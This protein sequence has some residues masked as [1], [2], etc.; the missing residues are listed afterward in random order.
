MI[1]KT[2]TLLQIKIILSIFLAINMTSAQ[3]ESVD[4]SLSSPYGPIKSEFLEMCAPYIKSDL[5][6]NNAC[7]LYFIGLRNGYLAGDKKATDRAALYYALDGDVAPA[8]DLKVKYWLKAKNAFENKAFQT[9][10]SHKVNCIRAL[11]V[12]SFLRDF[13]SFLE[14]HRR[15][16][17][18][19][20]LFDEFVQTQYAGKC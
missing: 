12:E 13:Y 6:S 9:L 5:V 3:A 2:P 4:K 11:P 14:K 19:T 10:D 17:G 8:G 15:D 1:I 7:F 16:N 18:V 20:I